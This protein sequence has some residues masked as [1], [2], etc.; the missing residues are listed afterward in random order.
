M[1]PRTS[2]EVRQKDAIRAEIAAADGA[3]QHQ[4][5]ASPGRLPGC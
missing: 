1:I 4:A 2:P 5:E 3:Q